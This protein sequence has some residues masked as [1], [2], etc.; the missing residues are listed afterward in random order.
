[1]IPPS[2]T[3]QISRQDRKQTP[4]PWGT[5]APPPEINSHRTGTQP[6]CKTLTVSSSFPA[7]VIR[8]WTTS[9]ARS[10]VFSAW[11]PRTHPSKRLRVLPGTCVPERNLDMS[12]TFSFSRFLDQYS[13]WFSSFGFLDGIS[14]PTVTGFDVNPPP[15][16]KSVPPGVLL[17]GRTGDPVANRPAWA[18]DGSFLVFRY[19]FQTVPEFNTFLKNNPVN[20]PGLVTSPEEASELTGARLVG[21]WKSGGF[22]L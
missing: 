10:G 6:S 22:S 14:N 5:A 21:R 2:S 19:L 15:G 7:T 1:M 20:A 18:V 11:V 16:P 12:S 13:N 17:L 3:T 4:R 9:C 8:L